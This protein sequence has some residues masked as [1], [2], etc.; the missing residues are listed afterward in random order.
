[1]S[2]LEYLPL[3]LTTRTHGTRKSI[4]K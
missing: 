2:F 3:Y 1:M 4:S